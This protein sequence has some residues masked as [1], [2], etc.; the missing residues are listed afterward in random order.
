MISSEYRGK[1]YRIHA[2]DSGV[3]YIGSTKGSLDGRLQVH[4]CYWRNDYQTNKGR[5]SSSRVF[6]YAESQGLPVQ[7][8]LVEEYP[9]ES[10]TELCKREGWYIENYE[11]VNKRIAGRNDKKRKRMADDMTKQTWK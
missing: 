5:Y 3:C 7:I 11:C 10:R 8:T 4:R 9:C 6:D 2:D 1:I